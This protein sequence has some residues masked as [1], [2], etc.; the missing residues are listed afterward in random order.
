VGWTAPVGESEYRVGRPLCSIGAVK[1]A[2]RCLHAGA[3]AGCGCDR[4]ARVCAPYCGV[5][6]VFVWDG[7][8]AVLL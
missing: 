3:P 4:A 6:R 1:T 5:M 8:V 2:R 7:A